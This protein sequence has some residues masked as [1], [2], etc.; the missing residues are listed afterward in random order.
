MHLTSLTARY[1]IDRQILVIM[2]EAIKADLDL[3]D[4]Q[5]GLL[6]GL[7]FALFYTIL[8]IP[9][10]RWADFANRRNIIA[11]ALAIWSGMTALSGLA[12]NFAQLA[13]A[14]VGVGIG[15]AATS[16]LDDLQYV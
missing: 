1:F 15:E 8:G 12:Q 14:R 13:L 9:I 7:A 6:S 11:I 10:A 2:Q 5:L 3:S 4:T 16:A